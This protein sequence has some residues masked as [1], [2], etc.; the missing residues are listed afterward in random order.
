MEP[1]VKVSPG[2]IVIGDY[3]LET[4][5]GRG[6]QSSVHVATNIETAEKV[7]LKVVRDMQLATI[8]DRVRFEEE[9]RIIKQLEHP[10]IVRILDSGAPDSKQFIAMEFVEGFNFEAWM[11][12]QKVISREDL[13]SSLREKRLPVFLKVCE[14]IQ[15]AHSRGIVHRDLKPANIIV[16][17]DDEPVVL[18]F[19]LALQRDSPLRYA[20]TQVAGFIGTKYFASPQQIHNKR[21]DVLCDVFALGTILFMVAT[22]QHPY[23]GLSNEEV[24]AFWKHGQPFPSAR[25]RNKMV[26]RDLDAIIHK[27]TSYRRRDRYQS[28]QELHDDVERFLNGE[29]VIAKPRSVASRAAWFAWRKRW[30]VSACVAGSV[31]FATIAAMYVR[32]MV[33]EAAM[34][35]YSSLPFEC[36][37]HARLGDED[38]YF[39]KA[40]RARTVLLQK[41][42]HA[43][44]PGDALSCVS[45]MKMLFDSI[46]ELPPS[47]RMAR[48]IVNGPPVP[49]L[50]VLIDDSFEWHLQQFEGEP[51]ALL[52]AVR[53]EMKT[54][55]NLDADQI[56][57]H[58]WS[59]YEEWGQSPHFGTIRNHLP[60]FV[61][62]MKKVS[63]L[64]TVDEQMKRNAHAWLNGKW[65]PV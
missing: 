12:G 28:V 60:N 7:A 33:R 45:A 46:A 56:G 13:N 42:E 8:E 2:R 48:W 4:H 55:C 26:P 5:L 21:A 49:S 38:A 30:A 51:H 58:G 41:L 20:N 64:R 36:R 22:N 23:Q 15:Y 44:Y 47:A 16:K 17:E 59:K 57:K 9:I 65:G 39:P 29:R 63:A 52:L 19:G 35:H 54:W 1:K 62:L 40:N 6:Q 37:M 34:I 61:P 3:L 50:D 25:H 32:S 11:G 24:N 31:V 43:R 10:N 18:D 14:A 53:D 27:A